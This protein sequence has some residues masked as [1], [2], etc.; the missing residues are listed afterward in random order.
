MII[1]ITNVSNTYISYMLY[2]AMNLLNL[3]NM[4]QKARKLEI[5]F[6]SLKI[7]FLPPL[8]SVGIYCK[9]ENRAN[10]LHDLTIENDDSFIHT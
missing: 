4:N 6:D 3:S 10:L 1:K 8:S 7:I 9:P 5:S 2:L